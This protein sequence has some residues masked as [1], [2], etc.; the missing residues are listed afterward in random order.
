LKSGS[1]YFVVELSDQ[2][3]PLRAAGMLMHIMVYTAVVAIQPFRVHASWLAAFAAVTIHIATSGIMFAL[4]SQIN[5]LNEASLDLSVP[6]GRDAALA[7]SWAVR[8]IETSN[9]FASDSMFWHF[10]SNGLNLQIEHHL[11]P[12]LNHCH[13]HK[14][15]SIV[16]AT[17]EE[18]GVRYESY[19]SWNDIFRATRSWLNVLISESDMELNGKP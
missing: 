3:R 11:F 8:Q 9:N 16:K 14:I 15:T 17:C 4:F 19:E 13:L 10:L 5:H 2:H 1:L 6:E 7:K 18:Y 12:G